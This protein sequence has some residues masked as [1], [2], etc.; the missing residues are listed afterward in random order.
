M[1]TLESIREVDLRG[2]LNNQSLQRARR[3]IHR[4]VNPVRSGQSL[5]AEVR[6]SRLYRVDIETGSEGLQAHC[7]C[8][9]DWGGY[10]KHIG[11]VLLKWIH[12][13]QSFAV[14]EPGGE[15]ADSNLQV[16]AV[17][18]PPPQQP[19]EKPSWLSQSFEERQQV[20][21]ANLEQGLQ[22]LRLQDLR[23]LADRR[24]WRV[25]ASRKAELAAQVAER[26][27]QP[28]QVREAVSGLDENHR[29][30]LRALVL[31]TGPLMPSPQDMRRAADLFGVPPK[32]PI[33]L[34]VRELCDLGLALPTEVFPDLHSGLAVVPPAILRQLPP[35]LQGVVPTYPELPSRPA[36]DELRSARPFDL[37][38]CANQ[39]I[40]LLEQTSYPRRPPQPRP[41][42]E[43]FMPELQRWDYV[44]EEVGHFPQKSRKDEF[45]LTVP[46]PAYRLPDEAIAQLAPIAG[47]AERLDF[48]FA[49]LLASG[50]VLEGSPVTPW[51]E[52]KAAF[53]QRDLLGQ[54]A[55]LA[56]SYIHTTDWSSLWEILRD[57][58]AP[59]ALQR[60]PRYRHYQPQDL[61]KALFDL[62][63]FVLHVLA[64]LPDGQWVVLADLEKLLQ[65]IWPYLPLPLP[66]SST[67]P[68][69]ARPWSLVQAGGKGNR[70]DAPAADWDHAQGALIRAIVGGPLHWL[71]L[72]E[73][74]LYRGELVAFRP[75]GLAELYRGRREIPAAIESAGR[76]APSEIIGETL[77]TDGEHVSLPRAAFQ[78]ALHRLLAKIGRLAESVGDRLVYRLDPMAAYEAFEAGSTLDDLLAEWAETMPQDMPKAI[79]QRLS[80]WWSGYG[81]VRL[82]EDITV[83]EFADD[84]ALAEMKA[85]T[86]LED[87]LIAEISPRLVLIPPEAIA[88][89]KAELE[90]AGYTPQETDE[91]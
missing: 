57:P 58:A 36:T 35:L 53:M 31:L 10:C 32:A 14:Q 24:R 16:V 41:H 61:R 44:P 11:A 42:M 64:T 1:P 63:Q 33:G 69:L 91:I 20:H 37:V 84:Y 38:Q 34:Y 4:V 18:M 75:L 48:L 43:R 3:Y 67:H 50:V 88:G 85:V 83:V 29:H 68:H 45:R 73:L 89:L 82:Y 12:N 22:E 54:W 2:L 87:H 72:V 70:A 27:V 78:P 49:L 46:A 39:L 86:S 28:D 90:R 62:R 19:S 25:K 55:V 56:R 66:H 13:P 17:D 5:S 26:M 15:K 59:V 40:L 65:K 51:P 8:P 71:G 23:Q 76:P 6:G 52:V 9:Y 80:T 79:Q 30:V 7:S 77:H 74:G 47:G 21:R 60:D 81:R